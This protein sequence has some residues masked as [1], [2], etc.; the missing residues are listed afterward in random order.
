MMRYWEVCRADLYNI[1]KPQHS[2][3]ACEESWKEKAENGTSHK[4]YNNAQ[5]TSAL[6]ET[7][8]MPAATL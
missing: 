7:L 5:V 3:A 2:R 1:T 6:Y 4:K 8:N